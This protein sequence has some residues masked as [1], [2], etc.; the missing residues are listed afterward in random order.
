MN[1]ALAIVF[2]GDV[3]VNRLQ[4]AQASQPGAS[5][6][7]D[8][9]AKSLA[10]VAKFRRKQGRLLHKEMKTCLDPKEKERQE[11]AL[12]PEQRRLLED[13]R[14]GRALHYQNE[15]VRAFGHGRLHDESGGYFDMGGSTGGLARQF[16]GDDINP[17]GEAWMQQVGPR[18][19]QPASSSLGAVPKR[20]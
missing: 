6:P 8:S 9:K 10:R 2:T 12:G 15:A 20:Q 16:M 11:R 3:D 18:Q 19:R 14:S 4:A 5:Q 13:F 17:D 7:G 1:L